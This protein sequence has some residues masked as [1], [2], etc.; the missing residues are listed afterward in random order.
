MCLHGKFPAVVGEISWV[1]NSNIS[2]R[3]AGSPHMYMKTNLKGRQD[4]GQA[5]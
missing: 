2:L 1:V 3:K 5:Y 4:F